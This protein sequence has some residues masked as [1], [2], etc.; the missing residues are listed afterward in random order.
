MERMKSEK[1]LAEANGFRIRNDTAFRS[2]EEIG[3]ID[4]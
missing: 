2:K 4:D 1:Q 3:T